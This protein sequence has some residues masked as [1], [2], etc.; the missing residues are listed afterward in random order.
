MRKILSFSNPLFTIFF[1]MT[2]S[3]KEETSWFVASLAMPRRRQRV[4]FAWMSAALF[5][6]MFVEKADIGIGG[7]GDH[8]S[9]LQ[10]ERRARGVSLNMVIL[11]G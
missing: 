11:S 7:V 5:G 3:R 6:N 9:C 1:S 10:R 2:I 4:A 8:M